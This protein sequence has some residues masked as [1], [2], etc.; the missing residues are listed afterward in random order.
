MRR[1]AAEVERKYVYR[2]IL[3]VW[4]VILGVLVC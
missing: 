3:G 2:V 4:S 1:R